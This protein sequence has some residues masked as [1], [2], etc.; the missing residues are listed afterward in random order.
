MG[1]MR[2]TGSP[3]GDRGMDQRA[4]RERQAGPCGMAE[5]LANSYLPDDE[6]TA[7][8]TFSRFG[9][10]MGFSAVGYVTK[11][12]WPTI[13][14]SLRI[15]RFVSSEQSDPGTVRPPR[16]EVPPIKPQR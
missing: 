12:Y 3:S 2:N 14:K 8:K 15:S 11:E 10:R 4:T 7:G 1:T 13:F 9:I 6:R 5:G 16:A